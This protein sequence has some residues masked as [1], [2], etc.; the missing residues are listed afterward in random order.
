MEVV[1][2]LSECLLFTKKYYSGGVNTGSKIQKRENIKRLFYGE[3][4]EFIEEINNETVVDFMGIILNP[5]DGN[6]LDAL[7]A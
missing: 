5:R 3:K 2:R 1:D 6:I 7:D 4:V